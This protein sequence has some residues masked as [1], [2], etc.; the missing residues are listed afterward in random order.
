MKYLVILLFM[1]MMA[2]PVWCKE[3]RR[4]RA[5]RKDMMRFMEALIR[6]AGWDGTSP[7]LNIEEGDNGEIFYTGVWLENGDLLNLS[8]A[9][10][11]DGE[12]S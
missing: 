3:A 1:G 9:Y 10:Y 12:A 11:L 4:E 6:A 7:I 2:Y 8:A 5:N